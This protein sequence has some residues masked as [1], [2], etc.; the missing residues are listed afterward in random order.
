MYCQLKGSWFCKIQSHLIHHDFPAIKAQCALNNNALFNITQAKLM[1]S[2]YP[3]QHVKFRPLIDYLFQLPPNFE[4]LEEFD[5][6]PAAADSSQQ[7]M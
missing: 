2:G 6:Q 3:Y 4:P 7:P 1:F 5:H